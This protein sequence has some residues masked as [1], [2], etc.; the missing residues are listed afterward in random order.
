MHPP[1]LDDLGL[2]SA[3]RWYTR[4]FEERSGIKLNVDI[5][6]DLERQTQEVETTIFRIVQEALT[7]VHRHSGTQTVAVRLAHANGYIT[8]EV[9]DYGCGIPFNGFSHRSRG[10]I[11]VGIQGM[12]ERVKELKGMF[13]IKNVAGKGTTV[14][15]MLPCAP[16]NPW[17]KDGDSKKASK[18]DANPNLQAKRAS[19]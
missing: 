17:K 11:G 12:R 3:L 6:D 15:V 10:L 18:L 2:G 14:Q 7:N 4:G 19:G 8:V 13:E 16:A 5:A 1:T 9:Q